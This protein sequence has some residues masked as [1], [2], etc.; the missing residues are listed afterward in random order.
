MFTLDFYVV[1]ILH[2]Q[3]LRPFYVRLQRNAS[4]WRIF[5]LILLPFFVHFIFIV[6]FW[7]I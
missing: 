2:L 4:K 6:P 3:F 5:H 7:R 1:E